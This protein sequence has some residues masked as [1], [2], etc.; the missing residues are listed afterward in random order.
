MSLRNRNRD[1]VLSA[2]FRITMNGL[3]SWLLNANRNLGY[4]EQ[5]P[6]SLFQ[7]VKK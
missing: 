7:E 4:Q 2:I 5:V 1:K 6:K 3:Y